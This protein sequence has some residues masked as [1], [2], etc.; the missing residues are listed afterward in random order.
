LRAKRFW[1]CA[2]A[3]FLV[4]TV[5]DVVALRLGLWHFPRGA[6]LPV[7]ILEL[8]LEEY[9]IFVIHTQV[10]AILLGVMRA[11]DSA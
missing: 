10:C 11:G 9:L 4:W 5:V 3:L 6:T 8:P 2:A 1:F 7:R